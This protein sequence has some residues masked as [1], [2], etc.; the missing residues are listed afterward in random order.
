MTVLKPLGVVAAATALL[1]LIANITA[2]SHSHPG[3][4]S[5]VFWILT[6]IGIFALVGLVVTA[7]VRQVRS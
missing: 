2:D 3:T 7:L 6:I 1:F 5:N 4:T